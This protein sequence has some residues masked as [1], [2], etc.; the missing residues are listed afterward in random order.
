M[1]GRGSRLVPCRTARYL[2]PPATPEV[3]PCT[4]SVLIGMPLVPVAGAGA[5]STQISWT[6]CPADAYPSP[7]LA[8]ELPGL[9]CGTFEVPYDYSRPNGKK[10][11]LA[12]QKLPASG[13]KIGTLFANRFYVDQLYAATVVRPLQFIAHLAAGFDRTVIDG[14]VDAV[15]GLPGAVGGIVRRLQSGLLQR[16]AL[17]G[18]MGTLIIVLALAW[19]LR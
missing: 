19:Q 17:A 16:Y 9:Q 12:L 1:P 14:V 18:M 11:T 2:P 15:S 13:R 10:F 4:P 7:K 5:Q 6:D 8:E 3:D